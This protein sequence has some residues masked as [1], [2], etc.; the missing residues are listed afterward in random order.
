MNTRKYPAWLRQ[1]VHFLDE[2]LW[3]N[4]PLGGRSKECTPI[5]IERYAGPRHKCKLEVSGPPHNFC[6]IMAVYSG[7]GRL[8]S[9]KNE[10]ELA[11]GMVSLTP[12]GIPHDE[13]SPEGMDTIW[14][15]FYGQYANKLKLTASVAV[16]DKQLIKQ[17]DQLW[18]FAF[19][20]R[21]QIGP[22]LD[23]G[24]AT[25]ATRLVRLIKDQNSDDRVGDHIDRTI[26][27]MFEHYT[28]PL[29]ISKLATYAGCS[30]GYFERTFQ[31]RTGKTPVEFLS[32]LRLR[33]ACNLLQHSKLN[34]S[35]IAE[36]TGYRDVFYF[37]RVFSRHIEVNPSNYRKQK[38]FEKQPK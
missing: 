12:P 21:R 10:I 34:I 23:A 32:D 1:H 4:S 30:T 33:Q 5:Y 22:E 27:Y 20:L 35:E 9:G 24:T 7:Y 13:V 26:K 28:E 14:I 29:V 15:G 3:E 2:A 31:K 38:H 36:R 19:T 17:I 8:I 6:E 25:I 11:P 18:L 37:S 16:Y